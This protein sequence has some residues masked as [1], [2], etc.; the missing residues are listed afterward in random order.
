MSDL[1]YDRSPIIGPS[2][3]VRDFASSDYDV[4]IMALE[5]TQRHVYGRR[6]ITWDGKVFK[7]GKSLGDLQSGYGAFN[8]GTQNIG[9]VPPAAYAAGDRTVLVTIAS[10]DGYAGD[11]V[12]DENELV[13]GYFVAGHDEVAAVQN[14][15]IEANTAVLATGGTCTLTLDFPIANAIATSSYVEIVLNPYR[16][17]NRTGGGL[18]YHAVMGVPVVNAST[19]YNVWLQ[20][21]GPAWLVPGGGDATPG[22]TVN[23]RTAYFVGDGSVNFGTALT[24]ETGYQ[25]AGFC[26]DTT[27]GPVSALPL[28]MLTISY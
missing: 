23:D 22:N 11:G 9:A 12:I 25:V 18:Q 1:I 6:F 27:A 20:T 4:S 3:G 28:V 8:I 2:S 13:G 19:G 17:L 7:Y 16:Y 24:L 26:I 21:A 14:R 15:T 5:T 10:G